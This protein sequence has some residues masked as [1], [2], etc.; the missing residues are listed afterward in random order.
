MTS[1]SLSL[2]PCALKLQNTSAKGLPSLTKTSFKIQSSGVKK[3]KVDKPLGIG[4]GMNLRD[5]VD[6]SGRKPTGK[7]VYQFVDKYGANV[8]GYS[9]I[10]NE[11]EWSPSGDVYAG[12]VTGLLIWAVTLAGI[13]GGGALLVYSTS[14]LSQ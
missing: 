3:I 11:E 6:A 8:D 13:L 10:Y 1:S 2:K 9:P 14:A 4:G 12:G 5:G 7:G